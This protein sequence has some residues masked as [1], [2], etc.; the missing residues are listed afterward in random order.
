MMKFY[1]TSGSRDLARPRFMTFRTRGSCQCRRCRWGI[2]VRRSI[3]ASV[4]PAFS[5]GQPHQCTRVHKVT[6]P[7]FRT[8]A[9]IQTAAVIT[10][11]TIP[12]GEVVALA[13]AVELRALVPDFECSLVMLK[14]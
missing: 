13:P 14:F 10:D 6:S 9:F 1:G 11:G 3:V 8:M 7:I 4:A 12:G 2:G 5:S